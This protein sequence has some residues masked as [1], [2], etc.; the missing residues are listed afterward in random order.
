MSHNSP[1]A[2]WLRRRSPETGNVNDV[3]GFDR[4]LF[5]QG[6]QPLPRRSGFEFKR[7]CKPNGALIVVYQSSAFV[8]Q[9]RNVDQ[10]MAELAPL[11]RHAHTPGGWV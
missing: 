6:W 11:I 7:Y 2:P 10:T 3:P 9:G 5:T 4:W 1:T 8:V